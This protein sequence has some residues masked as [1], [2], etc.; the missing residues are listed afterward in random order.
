MSQY[1]NHYNNEQPHQ[2][3]GYQIP[4]QTYQCLVSAS[5]I[6]IYTDLKNKCNFE[7]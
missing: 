6:L 7:K 3:L 1:F 4:R 5:I 2:S